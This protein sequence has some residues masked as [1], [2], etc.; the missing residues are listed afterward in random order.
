M[1]RFVKLTAIS[2]FS[3]FLLAGILLLV[4]VTISN[5]AYIL[6]FNVDYIP[7]LDHV[8]SQP[9]IGIVFHFVFC[10]ISVIGLYVF[11]MFFHYEKTV[12]PYIM[13]YTLGSACLFFLTALTDLA[14][15]ADDY[16]AWMAWTCA[17][18]LFGISVGLSVKHWT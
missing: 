10:T 15:A 12:L 13:V 2:V 17:H 1:Q 4:D 3:G 5:K 8:W 14:P 6:L 18:A 9:G 11:L 16:I 7:Y